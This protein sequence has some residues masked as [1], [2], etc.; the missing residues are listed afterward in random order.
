MRYGLFILLSLF[1]LQACDVEDKGNYDYTPLNGVTIEIPDTMQNQKLEKIIDTLRINPEVKGD[2]YGNNDENYE[3]KWFFCSGKDH[4]HTVVGTTKN[5]EWPVSFKPGNY[6][7][8]FQIIDKSTG[9]EWLTST[10]LTVF[11]EL[12]QGWLLLGE[13]ENQL[14]R[15]DM[16][17][18]KTDGSFVVID[19]VF[20][21]SEL[22]LKNARDMIY[23]G[24]RDRPGVPHHLWVMTEE[25]DM[26]V[27]W[28]SAFLPLGEFH[29]MLTV[30]E[31]EVSH[32]TPRIRD[33]FP[34]QTAIYGS[35]MNTMRNYNSRGIVTDKAIYM[36]TI[37]YDNSE[38]Y[39]N[40]M[41]RYGA[42]SK[43]FFKPYPMA[44]VL[45]GVGF[46]GNLNPLFYDMDAECFVKPAGSYGNKPL[47]CVKL[48]DRVGDA[49]PW[50]QN[51]RTI[52]YGENLIN[53]T[54]DYACNCVAL[55]KD[56]EGENINY[57]VYT[58]RP[59]RPAWYNGPLGEPTKVAGYTIDKSVAIDFDKATH[60][61]FASRGNVLLYSV[62]SILYAYDYSYKTLTS[63]DMGKEICCI[64]GNYV[65][66][67]AASY[68]VAT[69][70]ESSG[71]GE[72][73]YLELGG[74]NKP[75]L[76]YDEEDCWPVTMKIK[77][78]EWKY[79]EDPAE[80]EP[81]EEEEGK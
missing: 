60:Y 34:R 19:N 16:L 79:G 64:S 53:S 71:T 51:N 62:G 45:G 59:P 39:V 9:L 7:L 56:K 35:Y 37:G 32:E 40:P 47:N 57:Y 70:D 66:F 41:N 58:F 48:G 36:T 3:Y 50:N 27:T 74:A 15:L 14:V 11:S 5:L 23:A 78:I 65:Y 61:T 81:E 20:D 38:V 18:I 10:S 44:F 54:S 24:R 2:I 12:T 73:R 77:K 80:E 31:M 8:Y 49:F 25:K 22:Q 13:V 69:Y 55:M 28:G 17:T 26:K 29:E 76:I 68:W 75:E 72:L 52:V 46:N 4:K 67:G 6:V 30:E 63:M 33:M 43:E 21:N 1:L 42:T